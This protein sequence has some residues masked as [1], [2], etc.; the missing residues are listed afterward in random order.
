M[1]NSK[2][3]P[4]TT[5]STVYKQY[6]KEY[7]D[8]AKPRKEY[9]AIVKALFSEIMLRIIRG[10]DEWALPFGLGYIRVEKLEWRSVSNKSRPNNK[11]FTSYRE[12]T[13]GFYFKIVWRKDIRKHSRIRS[14]QFWTFAPVVDWKN[15]ELG[16]R[17]L[18]NYVIQRAI[19][20]K[21]KSY[22]LINKHRKGY[23]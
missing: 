3:E 22:D 14:A 6:A 9:Y 8:E 17:G 18:D 23:K 10:P 12:L 13:N 4:V 15:K 5:P 7:G 21:Q 11:Y 20:P 19:D 2:R 16:Q 1:Q